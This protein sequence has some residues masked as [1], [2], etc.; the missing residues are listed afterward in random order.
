[1]IEV[2]LFLVTKRFS[3]AD[4]KL[5][6]A[7]VRLI[8]VW[9]INLVHDAVTEREPNS[10]DRRCPRLLW[11]SRS[12]AARFQ[13][14]QMQLNFQVGSSARRWA[15]AIKPGLSSSFYFL[16]FSSFRCGPASVH[17]SHI[18]GQLYEDAVHDSLSGI[19]STARRLG[20]VSDHSPK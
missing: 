17:L 2:A 20:N 7:R 3:V 18:T 10:Y 11:R 8:D 1:M 5:K 15:F 16:R 9:I 14:R 4:K 13:A 12:S 6:V 19:A